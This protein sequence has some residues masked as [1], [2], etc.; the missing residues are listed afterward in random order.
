MRASLIAASFVQS[1]PYHS[2]GPT[3]ST[4]NPGTELN[5]GVAVQNTNW[6]GSSDSK[7]EPDAF[8]ELGLL[9]LLRL[10]ILEMVLY[11]R[12]KCAL[13]RGVDVHHHKTRGK[14]N[15]RVQQ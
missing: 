15:F 1:S 6:N 3:P 10:Y 14:D 5:S 4:G 12:S 11:S 8:R 9:T 13:V 2:S 7:K